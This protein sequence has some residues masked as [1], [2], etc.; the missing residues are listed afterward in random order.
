MNSDQKPSI[1]SNQDGPYIVKGLK[2]FANQK[3]SVDAKETMALCR[4]GA[5]ENKP[6]CDGAHAKIGF[7]SDKIEGRTKDSRDSYKG[8]RITIHDNRG[9]CAHAG[10][11][12]DGLASVFRMKEE[13]WIHPDSGS[14]EEVISTIEK[15][16]SGALSYTIDE[17]EH[18]DRNG[19]SSIFIAPNGPYVV[20]GESDLIDSP[21]GEGA[22]KTN[23]TLCRCGESK[24]KPFCDG[25]HWSVDF[26]DDK[27]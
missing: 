24:N 22:S 13:P 5:S 9:V 4:C 21:Q 18:R 8:Q 1:T 26:K 7:T 17:V 20:S 3:G 25:A 12:T 16:P 27:N 6:F 14:V 23:F 2:N 19:Q 15:C 10:I 11:C